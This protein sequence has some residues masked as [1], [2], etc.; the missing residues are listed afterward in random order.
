MRRDIERPN[1]R[2]WCR[3]TSR[4][5]RDV[6][7]GGIRDEEIQRRC[8]GGLSSHRGLP[9]EVSLIESFT[10]L[11][12]GKRKKTAH[13]TIIWGK[14]RNLGPWELRAA[15]AEAVKKGTRFFDCKKP[16]SLLFHKRSRSRQ[17]EE[18]K[19]RKKVVRLGQQKNCSGMKRA[20]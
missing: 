15:H 8:D 19:K 3:R 18:V 12:H 9:A 10:S 13:R 11:I 16:Q 2:E 7:E 14:K 5:R 20:S 17:P 1:F 4:R 6:Q